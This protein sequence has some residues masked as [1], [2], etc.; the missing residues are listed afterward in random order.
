[1]YSVYHGS[2]THWM[3]PK[4][5]K[6]QIVKIQFHC[7]LIQ[8]IQ[9]T[10]LVTKADQSANKIYKAHWGIV[11]ALSHSTNSKFSTPLIYKAKHAAIKCTK[12]LPQ[13][14][15][16]NL[17]FQIYSS[18]VIVSTIT[19]KVPH[20][21]NHSKSLF[22][23]ISGKNNAIIMRNMIYTT[24]P[25]IVGTGFLVHFRSFHGLSRIFNFLKILIPHRER[26]VVKAR[27][28]RQVVRIFIIC[29]MNKNLIYFY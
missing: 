23:H 9:F 2:T 6:N 24:I 12:N 21:K 8:S 15:I 27:I 13:A 1:V 5:V 25:C 26:N 14:G 10:A 22:V 16:L 17:I 4:I 19:I 7:A 18:S 11:I 20:A 29:N 3:S 28:H